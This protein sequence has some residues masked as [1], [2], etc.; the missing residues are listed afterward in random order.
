MLTD[1]WTYAFYNLIQS[2][3]KEDITKHDDLVTCMNV[4]KN[5]F[6]IIDDNCYKNGEEYERS[7][8]EENWRKNGY[9][10]NF[11][12]LG[13]IQLERQTRRYMEKD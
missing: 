13:F 4:N 5:F 3:V 2:N 9:K 12:L 6:G 10:S 8:N 1:L 7:N 11:L